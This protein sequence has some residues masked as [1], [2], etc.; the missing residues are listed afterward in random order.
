ME[1][2]LTL[3]NGLGWSIDNRTMYLVETADRVVFAYDHNE[4]TGEIRNRRA[5]IE[6][7]DGCI[8]SPDGMDVDSEGNLWIAMWD[9]WCI[10]KYSPAGEFLTEHSVPF[11]RPTSCLFLGKKDNRLIVTSARIRVSSN[12]LQEHPLA[13]SVVAISLS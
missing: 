5:F 13:G 6:F 2:N 1:T 4:D 9:G 12:L 7:D 11:P 3:P 10:R 8:G